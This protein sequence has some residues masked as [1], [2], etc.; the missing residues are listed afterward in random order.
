MKK[1]V[2]FMIIL[3]SMLIVWSS[4]D[5]YATGVDPIIDAVQDELLT[6]E[7]QVEFLIN[8][9]EARFATTCDLITVLGDLLSDALFFDYNC[10]NATYPTWSDI[11]DGVITLDNNSV[12]GV[13]FNVGELRFFADDL[14]RRVGNID[15]EDEALKKEALFTG[16]FYGAI[17]RYFYATYFGL[18]QEQGGGIISI[19]E[20]G[21]FIPSAE[22]YDLALEKFDAALSYTD[23]EYMKRVIN[24][25]IARIHLY[26]G[27]YP[28]ATTFAQNGLAE[29]EEP[30]QSLYNI[31]SQNNWY[32]HAGIQRTQGTADYRF[33][34]Y[35]VEDANEA[36]RVIIEEFVGND[37]TTIYYRQ[38]KYPENTSPIVFVSWQENELMLA[39]TELRGGNS[40]GALARI[41]NIRA[42]HGIDALTAVDLDVLY[43]ER[44]KEL[45]FTGLRLPDQRR[46]DKWH[47]G[48][49]TWKYL[50]ITERERN[51]NPNI[52]P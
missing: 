43:V 27:D 50:P 7:N 45:C 14:I 15:F 49:G 35:I 40:A 16:S 42:T 30:F 2:I 21:P 20:P 9:V 12:D 52:G 25:L 24:S 46:F 19:D 28:S 37:G 13:F 22:M 48:P 18:T 51:I 1:Q 47:L 44:D 26:K 23:D 31:E 6:S 41:N 10:P 8:G 17:A 29:G 3:F 4:C 39:E 33:H 11:N 34:D 5:D 38:F 32:I 36:N